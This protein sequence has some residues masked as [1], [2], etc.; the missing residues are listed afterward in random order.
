ME[1]HESEGGDDGGGKGGWGWSGDWSR[2]LS[3][4]VEVLKEQVKEQVEY[5]GKAFDPVEAQR[6][7][8][9]EEMQARIRRLEAALRK[10]CRTNRQEFEGKKKSRRK[11]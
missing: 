6:Q 5:A 8:D 4:S 9:V 3:E 1:K 11:N 10:V 2:K 7:K